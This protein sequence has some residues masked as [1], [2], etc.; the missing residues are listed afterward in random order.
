MSTIDAPKKRRRTAQL[1]L[2]AAVVIAAGLIGTAL[3]LDGARPARTPAQRKATVYARYA[4]SDW[5]K[6]GDPPGEWLSVFPEPGQT[7]DEYARATRHRRSNRRDTIYLRRLGPM[8][9]E[10]AAALAHMAEFTAVFFACEVKV[11]PPAELPEA[12]YVSRRRQYDASYILDRMARHVP[13]DALAYVGVTTNDLFSGKLSFVFGLASLRRRVAIYSL[14]RYGE[15][16]TPEFLRRALKVMAHETGHV[17]GLQHCIFYRCCMNGSNSLAES[18]SQP[19]HYCPL[20]HDKLRHALGFDPVERFEKLAAFY[21]KV[22][23]K[24]DAQ[25]VRERLAHFTASTAEEH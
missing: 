20:C 21:D 19:L 5:P 23:L 16:G 1:V 24:D 17:L 9:T 18:D 3:L 6:L 11:L 8:D 7:Y 12:A 2:L 25:F 22:G 14:C 10:T 4:E 13:D 15:P